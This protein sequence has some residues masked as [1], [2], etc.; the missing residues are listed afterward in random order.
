MDYNY[1]DL[2]KKNVVNVLDGKDLG[3]ISDIILSY[4]SG[5]IKSFI[6]P[7]QKRSFFASTELIINFKCIERIGENVIL[8]RLC[9]EPTPQ[10]VQASSSDCG[11]E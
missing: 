2:K 5:L 8:V 1:S 6:V 11:E 7:G 10:E 4:P 3:K 9:S